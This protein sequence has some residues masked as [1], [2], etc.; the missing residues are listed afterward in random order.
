LSQIK[1]F[2]AFIQ[3]R[4]GAL[5]CRLISQHEERVLDLGKVS[6]EG[7]LSDKQRHGAIAVARGA[8]TGKNVSLRRSSTAATST[9][10]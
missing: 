7:S 1:P 5:L 2:R 6:A 3:V 8:R 9:P 4:G 10:L